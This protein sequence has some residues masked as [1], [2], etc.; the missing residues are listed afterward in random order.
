LN[1][2]R[3]LAVDDASFAERAVGL[4]ED[5]EDFCLQQQRSLRVNEEDLAIHQQ[6]AAAR[7]QAIQFSDDIRCRLR[8]KSLAEG[9]AKHSRV[10]PVK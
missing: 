5:Y 9:I 4:S 10:E 8:E 6:A 7:D 1:F 3:N 2:A